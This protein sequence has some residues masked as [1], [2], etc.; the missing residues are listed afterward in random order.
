MRMRDKIVLLE[1]RIVFLESKIRKY[2]NAVY[3]LQGRVDYSSQNRIRGITYLGGREEQPVIPVPQTIKD[4]ILNLP[5]E[6]C[7]IG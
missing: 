7:G 3:D 4:D 1:K 2:Y 5:L 6:D